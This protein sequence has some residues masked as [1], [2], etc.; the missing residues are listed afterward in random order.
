MW[1][2]PR[3][4]AANV[5][6]PNGFSLSRSAEDRKELLDSLAWG[7]NQIGDDGDRVGAGLDHGCTIAPVYA[8]YG[9]QWLDDHG[10]GCPDSVETYDGI[11]N[12]LGQ[13]REHG[14]DG[15]VVRRVSPGAE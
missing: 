7:W 6:R 5:G 14:A 15:N 4:A 11:G 2:G 1:F 9:D 8:P 10:A 12:L 13:S 3:T